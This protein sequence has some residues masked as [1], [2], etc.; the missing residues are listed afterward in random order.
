[1]TIFHIVA[2]KENDSDDLHK[3]NIDVLDSILCH[4][5]SEIKVN[6]IGAYMKKSKRN[7]DYNIVKW[8]SFSYAI[9]ES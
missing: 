2:T 6:I 9:R 4:I 5:T 1:M 7:D 8:D 3:V